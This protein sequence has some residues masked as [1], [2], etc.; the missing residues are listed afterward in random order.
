[1]VIIDSY[2]DPN[3]GPGGIISVSDYLLLSPKQRRDVDSYVFESFES[4]TK[5]YVGKL[6]ELSK[7]SDLMVN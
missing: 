4:W 2:R 7:E 1:M 5:W 6:E 3:F